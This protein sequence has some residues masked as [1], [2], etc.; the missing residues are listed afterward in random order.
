MKSLLILTAMVFTAGA[1]SSQPAQTSRFHQRTNRTGRR[2]KS[3]HSLRHGRAADG[4]R[5]EGP[6][7]VGPEG[8]VVP[9]GL[10][11]RIQPPPEVIKTPHPRP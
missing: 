7:R 9:D 10:H 8:I 11:P 2:D 1:A 3:R 6:L 5:R 4:S